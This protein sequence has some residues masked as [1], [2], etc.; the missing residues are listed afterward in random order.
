VLLNGL[1]RLLTTIWTAIA[2]T[3]GSVARS[4]GHSAA[5]LEPEQKRDGVGFGLLGVAIIVAAALWWQIPGVVGEA[6]R[7][8]S[9]SS[10][11]LLAWALPLVLAVA[12]W[13]TLRHPDSNGPAGRQVIGWLSLSGGVLGLVHVA[14]GV[15]RPDDMA[16]VR[17]AG[18]AIGFLFSAVLID[19]LKSA[20]VVA[21]LLVL[22][23]AFGLLV[24]LVWL[25]MEILRLLAKMQDRRR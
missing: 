9:T 4:I 10:V 12:A 3:A 20:Y 16:A 7:S 5:E 22:P 24:T 18:G 25:Y 8:A 13:R 14:H 15:P 1:I 17:E 2:G 6:V 19:L 21:P 23:S 11:G